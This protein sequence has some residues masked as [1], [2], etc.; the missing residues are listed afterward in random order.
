MVAVM[1]G[2]RVPELGRDDRRRHIAMEHDARRRVAEPMEADS[3]PEDPLAAVIQAPSSETGARQGSLERLPRRPLV[4]RPT[5]PAGPD[6]TRGVG[7]P[8]DHAYGLPVREALSQGFRDRHPPP[9]STLRQLHE[10]LWSC[11]VAARLLV[12]GAL[13]TESPRSQVD[14]GPAE[15]HDL[16]ASQP[17]LRSRPDHRLHP[18]SAAPASRSG[19]QLAELVLIEDPLNGAPFFRRW[20]RQPEP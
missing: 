10:T 2:I 4:H 14:I 5:V 11:S 20:A 1:F 17:C 13:H 15:P 6:V 3:A 12:N 19:E 7:A 18:Q 8:F 16:A 9:P